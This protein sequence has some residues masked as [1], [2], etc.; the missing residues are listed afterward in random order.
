MP[1][2]TIFPNLEFE[3]ALSARG[4]PWSIVWQMKGQLSPPTYW[5]G[6]LVNGCLVV[7]QTIGERGWEVYSC[8]NG[9]K[10]QSVD[11]VLSRVGWRRAPK[12]R[13]LGMRE[14]GL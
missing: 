9:T 4:V 3:E 11:D 5:Q 14:S 10:A 8:L 7:H 13:S 2:K 1:A 12:D 6:Y